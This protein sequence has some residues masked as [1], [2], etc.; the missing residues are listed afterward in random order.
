[1]GVNKHM[2]TQ[3]S[4]NR[5]QCEPISGTLYFL[6]AQHV[7]HMF[8]GIMADKPKHRS[9]KETDSILYP[10]FVDFP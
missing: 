7:Q 6:L 9:A 8:F 1:M 4:L 3:S 5:D 10:I 2:D